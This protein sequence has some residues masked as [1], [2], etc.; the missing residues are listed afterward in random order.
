MKDQQHYWVNT[1]S[2]ST[3][4]YAKHANPIKHIGENKVN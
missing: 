3:Q 4:K 1:I 2:Q